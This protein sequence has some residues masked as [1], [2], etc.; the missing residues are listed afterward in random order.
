MK[1]PLDSVP[2]DSGASSEK[3]ESFTLGWTKVGRLRPLLENVTIYSSATVAR[4]FCAFCG[5][6]TVFGQ[7]SICACLAAKF[8]A[9]DPGKQGLRLRTE[10]D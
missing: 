8:P 4:D 10:A 6:F 7:S 9:A 1:T 2:Q 3:A 5:E